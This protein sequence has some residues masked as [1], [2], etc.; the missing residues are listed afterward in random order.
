MG[1]ARQ[2][3]FV[4]LFIC[5]FTNKITALVFG[6]L[7]ANSQQISAAP[8]MP[9]P[10]SLPYLAIIYIVV[11]SPLFVAISFMS[12]CFPHPDASR[13][14]LHFVLPGW[15]LRH[16]LLRWLRLVLVSHGLVQA[17]VS[18]KLVNVTFYEFFNVRFYK[19]L[20]RLLLND[21]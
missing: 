21:T 3:S 2:C 15:L 10:T 1:T 14:H 17:W 13:S 16:L 12:C 7:A 19:Y 20:R 4:Y 8:R 5:V 9:F 6:L 18:Q 11:V